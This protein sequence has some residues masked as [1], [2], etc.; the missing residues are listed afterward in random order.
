MGCDFYTL[1]VVCIEYTKDGKRKVYKYELDD[2][3]ERH[4]WMDLERDEDFEKWEDYCE[5]QS[6]YHEEQITAILQRDYPRIDICKDGVWK[7]INSAKEKY[8]EMVKSKNISEDSIVNVW[9][10]GDYWLR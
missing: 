6:K 7:C 1:Y 9:K 3:R 8:I 4:Y 5:R 2:T 10:E